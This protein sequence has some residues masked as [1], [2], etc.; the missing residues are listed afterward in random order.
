[1]ITWTNNRNRKGIF[2]KGRN[3]SNDEDIEEIILH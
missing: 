1:M 3:R 2:E